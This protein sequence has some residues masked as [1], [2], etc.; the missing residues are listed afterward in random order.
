MQYTFAKLLTKYRQFQL[1]SAVV[2]RFVY[3]GPRFINA[4]F[5][6]TFWFVILPPLC[7]THVDDYIVSP[8]CSQSVNT[9]KNESG[10]ILDIIVYLEDLHTHINYAKGVK[11]PVE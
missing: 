4:C 3:L 8:K 1:V 5:R 7:W 6:Q 11:K 10:K 9:P 2:K